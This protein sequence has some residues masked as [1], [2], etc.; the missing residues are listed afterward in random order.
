[1]ATLQQPLRDIEPDEAG[2]TED[3]DMHS[4]APDPTVPA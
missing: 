1:M 4:A 2:A 3:Q